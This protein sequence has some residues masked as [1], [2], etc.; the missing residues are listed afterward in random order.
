MDILNIPQ[1]M[2]QNMEKFIG[3]PLTAPTTEPTTFPR[4]PAAK[5]T[6]FMIATPGTAKTF[7]ATFA[8]DKYITSASCLIL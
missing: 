6:V 7:K 5:S 1:E 3:S 2:I 8:S 4:E